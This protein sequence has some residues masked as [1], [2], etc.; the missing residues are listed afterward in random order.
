M[1]DPAGAGLTGADQRSVLPDVGFT[2]GTSAPSPRAEPPAPPS[3]GDEQQAGDLA[4]TIARGLAAAGPPGWQRLEAVFALTV[5]AGVSFVHYVDGSDRVARS[6]PAPETLAAARAHRQIS[7]GLGAG[8]WWRMLLQLNRSGQ[9]EVDFDYGDE[10]FPEGQLLPPEAYIQDLEAHPRPRLPTWLAA[11]IGHADRQ[12]RTARTA[13]AAAEADRAAGTMPRPVTDLPPL[14]AMWARWA[15]I[16]ATFKAVGSPIGPRML[17]SLGYFEGAHRS[18]STLYLLPGGRAVLSGG[19][20]NDPALEAA[21]NDAA[22]MPNYYAGAPEWVANP[23]LDPRAGGGLLS[24]CHWWDR[25]GWYCGQSP[26]TTQLGEALPGI[27]TVATT[28][29]II[30]GQ[31]DGRQNVERRDAAETLVAAAE[32]GS[33]TRHHLADLFG[34]DADLA[35]AFYQLTLAGSTLESRA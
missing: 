1:N 6:E 35:S 19:V 15:V 33:A 11:Y 26:A 22:P 29:D 17:P 16:A 27:W 9:L 30:C 4:R 24:F 5:A 28:V 25:D 32:A 18:G 20:W 3:I 2:L 10:P 21:Y 13:A 34:P 31:L 12:R 14:P 8:P 7:A 23:V